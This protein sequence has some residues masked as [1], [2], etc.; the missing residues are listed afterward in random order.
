MNDI[1][2]FDKKNPTTLEI[3]KTKSEMNM[4]TRILKYIIIYVYMYESESKGILNSD[5]C[6]TQSQ[7]KGILKY[8]YTYMYLHFGHHNYTLIISALLPFY[9]S[10]DFSDIQK[11]N[12]PINIMAIGRVIDTPTSTVTNTTT[13]TAGNMELWELNG[14]L[15]MVG[16]DF[17]KFLFVIIH[18]SLRNQFENTL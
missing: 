17:L 15:E 16:N 2:F 9:W 8:M 1:F 3:E 11:S 6:T 12:L 7:A 18:A 4:Y 10:S 14:S 5:T 13:R